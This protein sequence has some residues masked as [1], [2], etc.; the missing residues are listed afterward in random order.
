MP[1]TSVTAIQRA[2][3]IVAL[4]VVNIILAAV[5]LGIGSMETQQHADLPAVPGATSVAGHATAP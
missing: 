2:R 1:Q 3:L 5:A 4:G